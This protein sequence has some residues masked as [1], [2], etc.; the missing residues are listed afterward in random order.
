MQ[1]AISILVSVPLIMALGCGP[2]QPNGDDEPS[3]P[4]GDLT[5]PTAPASKPP[6]PRVPPKPPR[7]PDKVSP[8]PAAKADPPKPAVVEV[9][10]GAIQIKGPYPAAVLERIVTNEA[11]PIRWCVAKETGV[12][13]DLDEK[14]T[15]TFKVVP[16]NAKLQDVKVESR[17]LSEEAKVCIVRRFEIARFQLIHLEG[18]TRVKAEVEIATK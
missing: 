12:V 14:V 1:H 2:D 5:I 6:E 18:E 10:V 3:S 15:I 16:K 7:K 17:K 11:E 4:A 8:K 13:A 9:V